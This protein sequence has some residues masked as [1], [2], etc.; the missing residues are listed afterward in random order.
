MFLPLRRRDG[1]AC[2]E[3]NIKDWEFQEVSLGET[4]SFSLRNSQFHRKKL[5]V[6]IFETRWNC[7]DNS[8]KL[9]GRYCSLNLLRQSFHEP[10]LGMDTPKEVMDS[11]K[12]VIDSPEKVIDKSD[13]KESITLF[14]Q[15]TQSRLRY[16]GDRMIDFRGK[17]FSSE[18]R[19]D[20]YLT[21]TRHRLGG[22]MGLLPR[23]AKT[24]IKP[25]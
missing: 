3:R 22:T 13:W 12:K 14:I 9:S 16:F 7:Q 4:R 19:R 10:F 15:L 20:R 1:N 8:L 25:V 17:T 2:W 24:T 23:N 6:S 21:H 5:W 18:G 11:S